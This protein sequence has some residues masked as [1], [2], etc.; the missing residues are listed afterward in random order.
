MRGVIAAVILGPF[1]LAWALTGNLC[2]QWWP[3]DY[4][5]SHASDMFMEVFLAF[6]IMFCIAIWIGALMCYLLIRARREGQ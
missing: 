3:R 2:G 1:A 4:T 5:C 6:S